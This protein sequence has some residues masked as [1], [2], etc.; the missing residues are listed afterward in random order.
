MINS[1]KNKKNRPLIAVSYFLFFIGAVCSLLVLNR[2]RNRSLESSRPSQLFM[3][4]EKSGLKAKLRSEDHE[5]QLE[6][7]EDLAWA[8]DV[9][10]EDKQIAIRIFG[11]E[12][13]LLSKSKNSQLA[14]AANALLEQLGGF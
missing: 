13:N 12:L 10:P 9:N 1:Q 7:I 8:I 2:V 5:T 14:T 4:I 11:N 3:Q 6:A